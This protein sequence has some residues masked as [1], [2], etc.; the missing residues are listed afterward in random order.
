MKTF[1]LLISL[2]LF[3]SLLPGC[4][5]LAIPS[6]GTATPASAPTATR[7]PVNAVP[8]AAS[9]ATTAPT[10]VPS[11]TPTPA[12]EWPQILWNRVYGESRADVG[13][14][15][16]LA[17]D[18]GFYLI[19]TTHFDLT[20]NNASGNLHLMRTDSAG[21]MLWEKSYGGDRVTTGLSLTPTID[22]NLLLVGTIKTP[23][24]GLDVYLVK[25]D[26]WGEEIWSQT[27]GGARDEMVSVSAQSDGSFLLW[28][29]SVDPNDVIADPGAAGYGGYTG[30]SNIFLAKVTA[31]GELIWSKIFG[32]Q[33]NLL[34]SGGVPAVDGGFVVLATRMDYPEPGD[35]AY[36]LK[37]D[38]NGQQVWERLWEEGT[39]S[40]YDL[41]RTADDAYL[42][43]A[44][45][46]PAD[47]VDRSMAD[48]LFIQVDDQG[49]DIWMSTFGNPEVI[50]YPLLVTPTGDGGY[51]AA[52]YWIKDLSGRYPGE[53]AL[54]RIDAAGQLLWK[55]TIKPGG[56]H[57][58]LR[59]W[60]Q[61]E[62][63]SLILMGSRFGADSQIYLLKVSA[64]DLLSDACTIDFALTFPPGMHEFSADRKMGN[65][66]FRSYDCLA[67]AWPKADRISMDEQGPLLVRLDVLTGLNVLT[68]LDVLTDLD[69]LNDLEVLTYKNS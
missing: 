51:L 47:D 49:Q 15:L 69:V 42:I 23:A 39:I 58:V 22:G 37:V 54:T 1:K 28:G 52:G 25:V 11:F 40:A 46:A 43:A 16:L 36:L 17:D 26:P 41:L 21:E 20:G 48:H 2:V 38:Q 7:L 6:Q 50:D 68:G 8:T 4:T 19:G 31:A 33:N 60:T 5:P 66:S 67:F 57:N 63:G 18:G 24:T 64:G 3:I 61:L 29:N 14:D 9:I 12:N 53:I 34:A 27:L 45:T 30:R 55:K 65:L 56:R 32:G 10:A 44:S 59:A 13:E 35:D 62:D